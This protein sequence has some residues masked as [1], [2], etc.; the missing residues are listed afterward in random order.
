MLT[1]ENCVLNS[2][3]M[4]IL[5]ELLKSSGGTLPVPLFGHGEVLNNTESESKKWEEIDSLVKDFVDYLAESEPEDSE[6]CACPEN[7]SL[8]CDGSYIFKFTP[9]QV[10]LIKNLHINIEDMSCEDIDVLTEIRNYLPSDE[11]V[12]KAS[13]AL[14]D[15]ATLDFRTASLICGLVGDEEFETKTY[16]KSQLVPEFIS[17]EN[18]EMF[19]DS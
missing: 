19:K 17:E 1:S 18:F 13:L 15:Q 4:G 9:D 12:K 14:E 8:C 6:E 2:I 5:L 7:G 11:D 3:P 16:A 10:A